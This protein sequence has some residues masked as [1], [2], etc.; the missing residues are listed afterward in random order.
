MGIDLFF[1]IIGAW[2]F[3]LGYSRGILGTIIGIFGFLLALVAS[4]KF[5]PAMSEFFQRA[6]HTNNPITFP[7]GFITIFMLI[8]FLLK[9]IRDKIDSGL[10]KINLNIFNKLAGGFI[11]A[12]L[13]SSFY[14]G[15]LQFMDRAQLLSDEVKED[16]K[17]YTLLK[18]LPDKTEKVWKKA[19]PFFLEFWN[20]S[21][22]FMDKMKEREQ[23]GRKNRE[24]GEEDGG[25]SEIFDVD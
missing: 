5:T 21:I 11:M 17:S 10:N 16:S 2:G 25:K 14:S 3:F 4:F 23:Q 24:E 13:L 18:A 19:Q 9:W 1:M 12:T 15:M 6:F 20:E 22:E 7:A 8:L